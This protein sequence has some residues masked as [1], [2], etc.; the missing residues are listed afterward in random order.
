[1]AAKCGLSIS[2]LAVASNR[3]DILTRFFTSGTM[4]AES[5]HS[6]F[7]P[8]MDIQ[9]SSNFERLLFDLCGQDGCEL[10]RYMEQMK[11]SGGFAVAPVQLAQARQIFSAAR[12]DDALTLKTIADVYRESGYVLDPHSAVGVAAARQLARELPNP[13]VMLACAHPA[14][15][16]ETI[17]RAIGIAPPLPPLVEDLLRKPERIVKLPADISVIQKFISERAVS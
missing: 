8:S 3:N 5:V 7:S 17:R 10:V 12:V 6:T 13:V 9:I 14:K 16:P 11:G 4:K 2:K 15:F 1:A